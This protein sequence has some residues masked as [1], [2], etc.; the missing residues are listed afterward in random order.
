M[1]LMNAGQLYWRLSAAGVDAPVRILIN[2]KFYEI[3]DVET[4]PSDGS[5]I[6]YAQPLLIEEDVSHARPTK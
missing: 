2:N 4:D 3:A 1:Y 6:L 5:V